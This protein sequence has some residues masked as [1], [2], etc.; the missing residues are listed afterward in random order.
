M[1][2]SSLRT[3]PLASASTERVAGDEAGKPS[4]SDRV[5]AAIIKGILSGR[6]VPGQKLIE[7]DLTHTLGMSRGPV[8]EALKRLDAQGV[9]ELTPHRGAYIGAMGREEASDL[10]VILE[11]LTALM[12]R[13]AAQAVSKGADADE[14]SDAYQWL[15][16]FRDGSRG[17]IA[18]IEKR[19]HFYDTLMAI[20]G[21]R[22]LHT[23]MPIMRIHL[24]RLQA[25]P[26]LSTEDRQNRLD[27]Y[28]AITHAVL[29][30][31]A[32]TA[33][34]AMRRHLKRMQQRITRL[35]DEA[36]PTIKG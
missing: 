1:A 22:Q 5:V 24:L 4:S 9:V 16:K 15:E 10:L 20:G 26:Y 18:F 17:D 3:A 35:P 21:N 25:Q 30:G 2:R 31:D 6:Y 28:S 7:A 13:L 11:D 23:V 32:K 33:E 12:A 36:F 29:D 27:E 34:R 14:M 19:R 8:R